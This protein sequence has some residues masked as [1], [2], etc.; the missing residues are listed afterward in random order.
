MKV[1][2]VPHRKHTQCTLGR[3]IGSWCLKKRT[4]FIDGRTNHISTLCGQ[5]GVS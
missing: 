1:L 4:L 3:P 5:N 2:F